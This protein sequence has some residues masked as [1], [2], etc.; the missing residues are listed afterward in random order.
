MNYGWSDGPPP[1]VGWWN[2][3]VRGGRDYWRWW[4]GKQWSVS[5]SPVFSAQT[6]AMSAMRPDSAARQPY[7]SWRYYWPDGAR[8]A[9]YNPETGFITGAGGQFGTGDNRF[10]IQ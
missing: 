4:D 2:A 7:I 9:R 1:H 6:A 5:A 10:D 8:C 3:S